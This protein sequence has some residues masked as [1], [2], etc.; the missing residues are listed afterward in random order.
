[1]I[2]SSAF[3]EDSL[4][5]DG[6]ELERQHDT[7][8]LYNVIQQHQ[9]NPKLFILALSCLLSAP[10]SCPAVVDARSSKS[11][12]FF[13]FPLLFLKK[14]YRRPTTVYRFFFFFFLF[15]F[16]LSSSPLMFTRAEENNQE[17]GER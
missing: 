12:F 1:M 10:K 11:F 15:L 17:L 8:L 3:I 14:E 2:L 4:G 6:G 16:C 9:E 7:F 5:Y 13:L